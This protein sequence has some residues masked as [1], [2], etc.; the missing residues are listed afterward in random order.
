MKNGLILYDGPS[1]I[2]DKPIIMIATGIFGK[3]DNNK[4]GNMIQTY[5]LRKDI[6]PHHAYT[7]GE[8]ESICGSCPHRGTSQKNPM[9]QGTCYV[10]VSQA[11][12]SIWK[13]YWNNGYDNNF[14]QEYK[15]KVKGRSI[16]LGSYGDPTAV[17]LNIL[18][19]FIFDS[20][21]H[22]GYTHRWKLK[23]NQ[24]YKDICMASVDSASEAEKAS[25]MGWRYFFVGSDL[26]EMDKSKYEFLCPASVEAGKRLS[27]E[28]CGACCGGKSKANVF[29]PVHGSAWK[30]NRMKTI[31]KLRYQKKKF[32][33]ILQSSKSKQNKEKELL[34]IYDKQQ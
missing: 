24:D 25:N 1:L 18:K 6:P 28:Q 32:S 26:S 29:I 19:E 12:V 17:P 4:T 13:K 20:S 30:V 31:A 3:S 7:I 27:C 33:H 23:E 10:N 22:T 34:K 11:P 14:N 9:G 21:L 8:D 16:R 2:D 15:D 5:I